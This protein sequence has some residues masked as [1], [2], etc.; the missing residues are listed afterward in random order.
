MKCFPWHFSHIKTKNCAVIF[1]TLTWSYKWHK[2]VWSFFIL[3]RVVISDI[4][5]CGQFS[6]DE[7]SSTSIWTVL[8]LWTTSLI[9]CGSLWWKMH[10]LMKASVRWY[11]SASLFFG[12]HMLI[13]LEAIGRNSP[14]P[15]SI[16]DNQTKHLLCT[17]HERIRSNPSS[18][19]IL[20]SVIKIN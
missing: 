7:M 19:K 16:M 6:W 17:Q 1:P 13:W 4:K 8:S 14:I 18:T 10:F 11:I 15:G 20:K 5:L 3:L 2:I 12:L 9:C